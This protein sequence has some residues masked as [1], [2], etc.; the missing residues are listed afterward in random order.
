MYIVGWISA[1]LN[2]SLGRIEKESDTHLLYSEEQITGLQGTTG[3]R[4]T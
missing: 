4:C 2:K 3:Q 1:E